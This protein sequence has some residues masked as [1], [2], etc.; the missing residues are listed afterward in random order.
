MVVKEPIHLRHVSTVNW[1]RED[2][3]ILD[4]KEFGYYYCTC[5]GHLGYM[6]QPYSMRLECGCPRGKFDLYRY[7]Q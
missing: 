1:N 4:P 5:L 3:T 2:L 7:T 6:P